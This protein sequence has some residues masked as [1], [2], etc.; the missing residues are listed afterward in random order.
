VSIGEALAEARRRADL[1]V[2][3]VSRQ[4]RIRETIITGIEGNDYS[5]CGGDLYVRGYIRSIAQAVGADPEPLIREYDTAQLAP[6]PIADDWTE[7]VPPVRKRRRL[8]LS[9]IAALVLVWLG[10]A[11]YNLLAGPLHTTSATPAATAHPVTRSPTAAGTQAPATPSPTNPATPASAGVRKLTPAG[12]AAFNPS[13]AGQGD[14]S[15][16]AHLAIDGKS[17][18]AWRT[19]W[20][21]TARFGNLYPGT[22]L[23][24]D[25][26]KAT[27]ITAA[28]ITLGRADGAD[29]QLRVGTAPAMADLS[30]VAHAANTGGVVRLRLSSPAHGRYVLIWF[31]SLPPDSS[32]TFQ[33]SVYNVRMEGP[34]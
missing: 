24:V 12:A 10:V 28:R 14:H 34:A 19:D 21:T 7:P 15:E 6:R 2:T 30:P 11:A 5:A 1:T 18:T 32:G 29:F 3:E 22:G 23:L 17:A 27:T 16:L 20:Y 9:W 13:G 4:T 31:T 25:M 8:R 26:G 33:V